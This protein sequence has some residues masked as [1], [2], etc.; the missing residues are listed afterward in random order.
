[1]LKSEITGLISSGAGLDINEGDNN[2]DTSISYPSLTGNI[3]NS[4]SSPIRNI[5]FQYELSNG[6]VITDS[7]EYNIEPGGST[8]FSYPKILYS[9]ILT[10]ST[11]D[12]E[13]SSILEVYCNAT[14]ND[15]YSPGKPINIGEYNIQV[16]EPRTEQ[17]VRFKAREYESSELISANDFVDVYKLINAEGGSYYQKRIELDEGGICMLPSGT[18]IRVAS[19]PYGLTFEKTDPR[20]GTT[21]INLD[22]YVVTKGLNAILNVP[23]YSDFTQIPGTD[24]YS[25]T[26]TLKRFNPVLQKYDDEPYVATINTQEPNKYGVIEK[27]IIERP[28]VGVKGLAN[29]K[30]NFAD[31]QYFVTQELENVELAALPSG[32]HVCKYGE[33]QTA[34]KG[35]MEKLP[36]DTGTYYL[37][38]DV[39]VNDM[40][41]IQSGKTVKLCLNGYSIKMS[42][43]NL[44]DELNGENASKTKTFY[45]NQGNLYIYDCHDKDEVCR[46][47]FDVGTDGV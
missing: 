1:M 41:T 30:A 13:N 3:F 39:T 29:L 6:D 35:S 32:P 43:N 15:P 12:V 11:P 2:L 37:D 24:D 10:L 5:D 42:S 14:I 40:A 16:E 19:K 9:G 34:L 33:F 31:T 20:E 22:N 38:G 25:I 26:A 21:Y 7:L 28:S 4:T 18:R 8:A 45:R 17:T 47:Y 36:S 27:E 44:V 46:H 23:L